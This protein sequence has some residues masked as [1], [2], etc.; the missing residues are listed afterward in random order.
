MQAGAH[1]FSWLDLC[2][3]IDFFL[4]KGYFGSKIPGLSPVL[5]NV[6]ALC[7][8]SRTGLRLRREE[9]TLVPLIIL[10]EETRTLNA[11]V[12]VDKVY[13]LMGLAEEPGQITVDYS[14]SVKDLYTQVTRVLLEPPL[15]AWPVTY[16]LQVLASVNQYSTFSI[17]GQQKQREFRES[18]PSW[19]VNWDNLTEDNSAEIEQENWPRVAPMFRISAVAKFCSGGKEYPGPVD[20]RQTPYEI[21]LRGFFF[22]EVST[23][24]SICRLPALSRSQLWD[25]VLE[26]WSMQQD[27]HMPYPTGESMD[28]AF[29]K[30]LTMSDP[31]P[32]SRTA[33]DT[34]HGIDFQHFC[35][36][37]YEQTI[38]ILTNQ[39]R[40]ADIESLSKEWEVEYLRLKSLVGS[41]IKSDTFSRDMQ[42]NCGGRMLFSMK[43]GHIGIGDNA[44]APGDIVCVFLG[45]RTPHVLRP[46]EDGKYKFI[47]ECY[48][49]GIMYGEALKEGLIREKQFTLI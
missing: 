19:V 24:V 5:M 44:L 45:G 2:H 35:V 32:A 30:T 12:P 7:K 46:V 40:T 31:D 4:W 10:L 15:R 41:H 13:A 20:D 37:M 33:G 8:W 27:K 47:G 42:R 38:S 11:T 28:E 22:A 1:L 23:C 49:H 29:A 3:A 26:I 21:S 36:A 14:M 9:R 48:L 25:F 34:Y 18:V 17:R 6:R 16:P 43:N 39:G